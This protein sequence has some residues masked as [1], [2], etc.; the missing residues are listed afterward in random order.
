METSSQSTPWLRTSAPSSSSFDLP[1]QSTSVRTSAAQL[2][3]SSAWTT[4]ANSDDGSSSTHPSPSWSVG[5]RTSSGIQNEEPTPSGELTYISPHQ[6]SSHFRSPPTAMKDA[7]AV[8]DPSTFFSARFLDNMQNASSVSARTAVHLAAPAGQTFVPLNIT[9]FRYSVSTPMTLSRKR[10][11]KDS[12]NSTTLDETESSNESGP[13]KR[14]RP[15][16][17]GEAAR[18][19]TIP[20]RPAKLELRTN[21][22]LKNAEEIHMDVWRIILKNSPLRFLLSAKTINR[23]FYDLLKT[24]STIW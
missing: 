11:F 7:A 17:A 1:P 4:L 18:R 5:K 19:K 20:T 8:P 12:K 21:K 6:I 9:D 13:T 24:E 16:C 3:C 23:R 15:A 2:V 14:L 22:P 10:F